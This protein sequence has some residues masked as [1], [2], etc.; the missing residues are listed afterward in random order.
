M[1]DEC[2]KAFESEWNKYP[3]NG[4]LEYYHKEAAFSF[5]R[6]AWNHR[7]APKSDAVREAVH[8]CGWS[9][10]EWSE[11]W[12]SGCGAEWIFPDGG[13]AENDMKFCPSCGKPVAIATLA[14]LAQADKGGV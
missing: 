1:G 10:D 13:P 4:K 11:S 6:S 2:R 12:F 8:E 9:R 5:F 7:P 3:A 14:A